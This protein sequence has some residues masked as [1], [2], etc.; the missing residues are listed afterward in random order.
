MQRPTKL[1]LIEDNRSIANA[2]AAALQTNYTV[3]IAATGKQGLYKSDLTDYA[4]VILDLNLPDVPGLAVCQQ[5]R[6]RGLTA[7]ILIVSGENSVL[8][9]IKLLD[10]GA[11]DYVT[12][13]C[14]LGELKARLRSLI[15]Q[16]DVAMPRTSI[17]QAGEL[18]LNSVTHAV[19]R[20]GIPINLRRK[21]F[22]LLECLLSY[23]GGIVSRKTLT[24]YAW[25]G[26]DENWT[27]TVDVH[28]KHLRDKVDR[29][30]N[31]SMIK[32]VHGIGYRIEVPKTTS[33]VSHDVLTLPV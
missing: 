24:R 18:S 25:E 30:F 10:A 3:D 31:V 1:L 14:S 4:A 16:T 22:S 23:K 2:L 21:E 19:I 32:T 5:L 33:P 26:N 13:P 8:S 6:E 27:N 11:N 28:I 9:K 20:E 15:R 29:P 17:L 7:P 12:K